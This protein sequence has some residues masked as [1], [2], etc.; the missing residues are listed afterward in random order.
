MKKLEILSDEEIR[1]QIEYVLRNNDLPLE[2]LLK[3]L[4]ESV[5]Q[6]QLDKDKKSA[7]EQEIRW[8]EKYNINAKGYY[9]YPI[10]IPAEDLQAL[11][12]QLEE[13]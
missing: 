7:L 4:C 12:E 3:P 1:Y 10:E 13:G 5:A 6:A 2:T 8:L 11:L 9:Q